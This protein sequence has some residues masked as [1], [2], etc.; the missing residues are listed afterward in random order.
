MNGSVQ[1]IDVPRPFG[2]TGIATTDWTENTYVNSWGTNPTRIPNVPII[3]RTTFLDVPINLRAVALRANHNHLRRN[4]VERRQTL[5]REFHA[6]IILYIRDEVLSD[7]SDD[8]WL[9][10]LSD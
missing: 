10:E 3:R 8:G 6:R 4:C 7:D 9:E 5:Q 2:K 1:W